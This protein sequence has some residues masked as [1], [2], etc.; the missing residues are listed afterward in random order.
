MPRHGDSFIVRLVGCIEVCCVLCVFL[1][2]RRSPVPISYEALTPTLQVAF[3]GLHA[4]T[5]SAALPT[6]RM[7]FSHMCALLRLVTGQVR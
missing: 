5:V 7:P 4:F 6:R 3:L 1:M 2:P